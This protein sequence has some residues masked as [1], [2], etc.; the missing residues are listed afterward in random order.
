[1]VA[2]LTELMCYESIIYGYGTHHCT[3]EILETT[4][5]RN[6]S[7]I[8]LFFS[9]LAFPMSSISFPETNKQME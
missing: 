5:V 3:Q 7:T 1:M 2:V 8:F 9:M 4:V 6:N